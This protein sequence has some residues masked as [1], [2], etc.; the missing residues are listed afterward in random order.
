V[1]Y[2]AIFAPRGKARATRRKIVIEGEQLEEA[3]SLERF[4]RYL[5]SGGFQ[6]C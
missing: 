4:G 2:I 5:S 3:L 6:D 1:T